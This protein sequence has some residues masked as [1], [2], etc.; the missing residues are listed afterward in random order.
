MRRH[1]RASSKCK[2]Y[3]AKSSG[4][5]TER[6]GVDRGREIYVHKADKENELE[7]RKW[8]GGSYSVGMGWAGGR[9]WSLASIK[10]NKVY[11]SE[12]MPLPS[13]ID[14]GIPTPAPDRKLT[15][16]ADENTTD[17]VPVFCKCKDKR[18]WCSTRRYACVKADVKCVVACHGGGDN[19]NI[20]C[21][22]LELTGGVGWW[23]GCHHD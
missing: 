16:H 2:R 9:L 18:S 1:E 3:G 6:I 8:T 11:T 17:R 22:N 21:P 14:L 23:G 4:G 15:L 12:L 10:S 7:G 13:T 5:K 20:E 19:S